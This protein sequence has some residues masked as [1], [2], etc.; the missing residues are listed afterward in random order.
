MD[1]SPSWW[2]TCFS[3]LMLDALRVMYN[4]AQTQAQADFIVQVLSPQP[5]ARIAD[6]PC[7]GGRLSLALAARGFDLTGVDLTAALVE[8]AGSAAR[9]RGLP[10]AF[11]QRDMRD[12][13]WEEAFDHV[14][15][16]GNSFSYF[17]EPGNA[18]F[19]QAVRRILK[20]G[21]TF[22]LETHFAAECILTQPLGRRWYPVGDLLFLHDSRYDPVTARLTSDYVVLRDCRVERKQAVYQI[23]TYREL[24]RL[25][26]ET[27]LQEIASYG[28]LKREPFHLGSPGLWMLATRN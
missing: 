19:L 22:L 6:V 20:P 10:A 7:G 27:G 14:F 11:H 24:R 8:E 28:S 2:Q 18:A 4:D 16:F 21:G 12:L 25:F 26:H 5:G 15:C 1:Q 3:G 9:E 17:D 23:Y 13:P